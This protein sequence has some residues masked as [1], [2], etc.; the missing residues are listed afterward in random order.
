MKNQNW[1]EC[2]LP[3][4]GVIDVPV[5]SSKSSKS[6]SRLPNVKN[7]RPHTWQHSALQ[8][9]YCH[10][11]YHSN[12]QSSP[13][14][15]GLS[16]R[17]SQRRSRGWLGRSSS[18]VCLRA[19]TTTAM[20]TSGPGG[21]C[22]RWVGVRPA[23]FSSDG[24]GRRSDRGRPWRS[25]ARGRCTDTRPTRRQQDRDRARRTWAPRSTCLPAPSASTGRSPIAHA[26]HS[27]CKVKK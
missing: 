16:S 27:Q 20:R 1:C 17:E 13:A 14:T 3:T 5:F 7:W 2:L 15:G 10:H 25:S 4:A 21:W 6:F 8:A 18:W 24:T 11:H 12:H 23:S 9:C 19:R 26:D 22:H